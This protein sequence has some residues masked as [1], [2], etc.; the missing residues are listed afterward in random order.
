M[1]EALENVIQRET[2]C[3]VAINVDEANIVDN[4]L[5]LS[6]AYGEGLGKG[7]IPY[8]PQACGNWWNF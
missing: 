3:F 6:H 1:V 8:L 2:R 4:Q 7:A 5:W